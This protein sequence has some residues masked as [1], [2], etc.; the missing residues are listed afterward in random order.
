[1]KLFPFSFHAFSEIKQA[2]E[3]YSFVVRLVL[4][5]FLAS[6]IWLGITN[7]EFILSRETFS[8]FAVFY[9]SI[10][11]LLGLD[12]FRRPKSHIRRYITL[13][14]DIS[15]TSYA[16]LLTGSGNSEFMLIYIWLYIAYGTRYGL[17]YL[18]TAVVLVIFEYNIILI[19]SNS[20]TV[21]PLSAAAQLFI[22]L[23]MPLYLF[24]M[25]NK[26]RKAKLGAEK[27]T[28]AK[29]NFLATMSHEIRTPMSSIIGTVHLLKK[30]QLTS[31]QKEYSNA[32]LNAARSLQ[33]LIG[34]ILDFSK[35]EANK[36]ELSADVFDL[37]HT[38][39]EVMS[40]LSSNAE[41]K[42]LNFSLYI[43]PHIPCYVIGDSQRIR[44]VLFN[45]LGNAIKFT[46]QGDV[47]L[48]VTFDQDATKQKKNYIALRFDIEDTGIGISNEQK[49][50]IF[51]SFTQADD[52][53]CS[54]YG[55]T[56]LGTTI[57]KQLVEFMGGKIGFESDPDQGS[58]F[59]FTLS[60]KVDHAGNFESSFYQRFSGKKLAFITTN[61]AHFVAL[62]NYC[63]YFGLEF[64]HFISDTE[65]LDSLQTFA[66]EKQT[67]DII[68][69]SNYD[70]GDKTITQLT[71]SIRTAFP[72]R[73]TPK[74]VLLSHLRN[75]TSVDYSGHITFDSCISTPINFQT[76]GDTLSEL[77]LNTAS[78]TESSLHNYQST[79][80]FNIL[81]AEDDDINAMVLTSFL[82]E[83]GHK[84][85][86]V[87]TGI[88]ALGQLSAHDF[89]IAFMDM[90]MP[91]MNG[92]EATRMWRAKEKEQKKHPAHIPILA[93]TANAT[94]E[95]RQ[96]CLEAGM[97]DFITKPVSPEQLNLI[98]S[99]FIS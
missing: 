56:G 37:Q 36:L 47:S 78:I 27:A 14:F 19:L 80:G 2:K 35:I 3:F 39:N 10:T 81:I 90:S 77:L 93:L 94:T 30:T 38:V 89:D 76:L 6:Y 97:D 63:D 91:E 57:S 46:E 17:P 92:V 71:R 1:M 88:E 59:W 79:A 62:Q 34:D 11:L 53:N 44:Q 29:S 43:D 61:Y 48:K 5:I 72:E 50:K 51:D 42:D 68:L 13:I 74:M 84:T 24:S 32:L 95:D 65:L 25:I 55:G 64:H 33:A 4:G 8:N 49:D 66:D 23:V 20:W 98:L 9:F 70:K 45:L 28:Q 86:R 58:H 7:Q 22:L 85:T 12:L 16:A 26:L 52:L 96:T 21:Q 40:V 41:Q 69:L 99:K 67:Y 31:A 83:M 87:I 75:Q 18:L 73:L 54:K 15:C 82:Q 60:L